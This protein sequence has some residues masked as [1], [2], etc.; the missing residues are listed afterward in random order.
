M[1]EEKTLPVEESIG[2][3]STMVYSMTEE[4]MGPMGEPASP[5]FGS[6]SVADN[7]M[8]TGAATYTIP[9]KVPPGRNRLANTTEI[10]F[11]SNHSRPRVTASSDTHQRN[12]A[13]CSHGLPR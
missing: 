13:R 8:F 5:W 7:Y 11:S 2:M 6:A 3:A 10:P 1:V 4:D 9:I 12:G